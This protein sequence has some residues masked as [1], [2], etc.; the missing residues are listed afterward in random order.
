MKKPFLQIAIALLLTLKFTAINAQAPQKMSYQALIRTAGNVLV[1]SSPVGMQI[2]ILQGSATGTAVYV[3][4][5]MAVTSTDGL[6]TIEI[7]N[8]VP[9]TGTFSAIDWSAGPY[10]I[11]SETDPAGGTAYS[12]TATSQ[13]LSVPYALYA[14]RAGSGGVTGATG[15]TGATGLDGATGADG[16]I[17]LDGTTGL[18]G[19]TGLNGVTGADGATGATGIAGADG[20]TGPAGVAGATGVIGIT[21]ATGSSGA[22]GVTGSTGA[23]GIA[24]ATGVTGATGTAGLLPNGTAAGNTP[25]WNGSAWVVNNSNIYNNGGNIGVNTAAPSAKLHVKGDADNTQLIVQA[26]AIQSN[27]NPLMKFQKSDGSDLLWINSDHVSNVFVGQ[28]SGLHNISGS[29]QYNTLIGSTAGNANTSGA[30]NTV[31]GAAA[32]NANTTGSYNTANGYRA[33]YANV[34]GF[35]NTACGENALFSNQG[36]NFATAIGTDAMYFANDATGSFVNTNVAVGYRSLYGSP[37]ASANTGLN[38]TAVGYLSLFANTTGN[39][40]T[41]LGYEALMT[42]TIGS[43]NTASGRWALYSNLNGSTNVATGYNALRLNTSG[44]S[45]TGDGQNAL[46]SNTT[47]NFNTALGCQALYY[48]TTGTANTAIGFNCGPTSAGLTNTTAIGYGAIPTASN[49]VRIGNSSVTTIE[50]QVAYSFPSDARFKYNVQNNVPGLDFIMKLTPVT[51][52]F[53]EQGL[54]KFSATGEIDKS[55]RE[56]AKNQELHTGF[57][58]QDIEKACKELNFKFDGLHTP[59]SDKDHYSLAY[60]QFIMPLVK[61]VQ[62]Q[63]VII[64]NLKKQNAEFAATQKSIMER[65]IQLEAATGSKKDNAADATAEIKK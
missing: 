10:F 58:A 17:G 62:E 61:A 26:N 38:N 5:Q 21:G 48:N 43:S 45:N 31:A 20:A 29:G 57:L 33:L 7:G 37:T 14:E 23:T 4:T 47:G 52:Y 11:K 30:Y 63:Q 24:G 42:N 25:Y 65:L 35:Y 60:S 3:E 53:D 32:L 64:E 27:A 9:V 56:A 54:Q 6:L 15:I 1:T 16:A 50:G 49:M 12:I 13:L 39:E 41:A 34:T 44:S 59:L 46:Q 18:N 28:S 40:N 19:A 51:Y 22:D 55:F 8:G 2:S 36:G